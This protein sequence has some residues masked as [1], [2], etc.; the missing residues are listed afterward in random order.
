MAMIGGGLYYFYGYWQT[1][2]KPIE[3]KVSVAAPAVSPDGAGAVAAPAANVAVPSGQYPPAATSAPESKP[4]LSEDDYKP[5][6]DGQPWTAPIYNAHNKSIKTMPFPAVCVKTESKCTCYTDQA[7]L[8]KGIKKSQ[9]IDYAENGIYHPY[10]DRQT[11]ANTDQTVA[12]PAVEPQQVLV[13]GGA[14]KSN[15]M[16]DGYVE[17]RVNM[18]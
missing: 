2:N 15:L 7:T 5:V 10:R 9:C 8:I 1:F 4:H 16:Y 12:L 3:A 14:S 17:A 6:L 13:M 18:Q 11:V